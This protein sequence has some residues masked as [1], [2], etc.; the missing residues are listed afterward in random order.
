MQGSQVLSHQTRL[1]I[2]FGL[3]L[4]YGLVPNHTSEHPK[5]VPTEA[6]IVLVCGSSFS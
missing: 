5:I 1:S 3:I 6:D 2:T 4:V